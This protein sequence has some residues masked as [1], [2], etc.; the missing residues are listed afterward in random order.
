MKTLTAILLLVLIA[1]CSQTDKHVDSSISIS[2]TQEVKEPLERTPTTEPTQPE[3]HEFNCVR[4]APEASLDLAVYPSRQFML[5]E[6]TSATEAVDLNNGDKLIINHGGCEYYVQTYRFETTRWKADTTDLSFW[7]NKAVQLLSEIEKADQS[8]IDIK[9]GMNAI[10]KYI[11]QNKEMQLAYDLDF[12]DSEIREFV[13]LD[14]IEK[15]D[16]GKFAVEVTFAIG[17]L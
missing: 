6:S 8:P 13:S 3:I 4:G 1:A 17:P 15:L 5:I 7:Y 9:A 16:H 12:A 10:A 11:D 2:N 14:R